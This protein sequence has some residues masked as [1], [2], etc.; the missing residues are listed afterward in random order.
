MRN[1]RQTNKIRKGYYRKQK[2]VE[3]EVIQQEQ[4][5]IHCFEKNKGNYGRIRIR[6]ALLRDGIEVSEYRIARI[7]KR[8]VDVKGERS[9]QSRQNSSISIKDKCRQ[10]RCR[11]RLFLCGIIDVATQRLVGWA[12]ARNQAQSIVQIAFL[13]A[14]GRN[15]E[16]PERAVLHSDR[17]CQYTTKR[18]KELVESNG[19]R[20]SMSPPGSPKD[21]QPIES[22]AHSNVSFRILA[23][24][25]STKLRP[26]L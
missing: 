9:L 12:I 3:R 6:K 8:R 2:A 7:L 5:V 22:G 10:M 14:I 17:G 4:E 21:N 15:P 19:F 1:T 26:R 18:T 25:H 23:S 24:S 13:M 16:I 20:K 11:V